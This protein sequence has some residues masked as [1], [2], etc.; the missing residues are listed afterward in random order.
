[1]PV[2]ARPEAAPSGTDEADG[3]SRPDRPEDPA[4]RD[5]PAFRNALAATD[6]GQ[7][8]PAANENGAAAAA[9]RVGVD[10]LE[11]LMT[12]AGE[13]VLTRNQLTQLTR[14]A[15]A[16]PMTAPVQRLSRLATELQDVVMKTRMQ[17][18]G[19]AWNKLPRLVRDLSHELGKPIELV[20]LGA[21]T[22]LDRQVLEQ[23]R[24]PLTHIV[25]N[26]ADHG[27]ETASVRRAAG[28]P[29]CG[30]IVLKASHESGHVVIEVRD[31]GRGLDLERI[32]ARIVARGLATEAEL[33]AM[34]ER[35]I[36]QYIFV[37]GFSTAEAVTSVSGRG[38][39]MDVVRSNI[40]RISG[41]VELASVPG[42]GTTISIRI[43]LTLAIVPGLVVQAAGQRF[44]LPQ[45][46]V[47]ELVRAGTGPEDAVRVEPLGGGAVLRLRDA[48]LPLVDLA[49]LLGLA[50]AEGR[51]A[52][53]QVIIVTRAAGAEF[54][55]TV[56]TVFDTE[57]IVV[58]PVAPPL[59]HL[60]PFGGTTILGDGT[61]TMILDPIGVARAAAI[62][63]HTATAS[64][65]PAG[66]GA[67]SSEASLE[68]LLLFQA[69]GA[70][71][72]VPLAAVTRLETVAGDHVE[73]SGGRRLVQYRG[74]LM[75]L[76]P[77]A[78]MPDRPLHDVLVLQ[79]DATLVGV[80]VDAI[81]DIVEAAVTLE[82]AGG[83]P[84]VVGT[85][86]IAG[87][88]TELIDPGHY[89]RLADDTRRGATGRGGR[90]AKNG[91][92]NPSPERR[93]A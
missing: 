61:V 67:A 44:V 53:D 15:D 91:R 36:Q 92:K 85:A 23:I 93:V 20:M 30:H 46:A 5:A 60:L 79:Q 71:M 80:V 48:L 32:R 87:R 64:E 84:G 69:G 17:P 11:Q 52:R 66:N 38:V 63:T 13:L 29:E 73:T 54:G 47:A 34:T 6:P 70:P 33:A 56:D 86:V 76:I 65:T 22:E 62:A 89:I 31:D 51:D 18:I 2:P 88:A 75:P 81:V 74:S 83:R 3:P 50:P 55:L 49:A 9:V 27:L 8:A 24:D 28:K 19:S 16:S 77:V 35:Q 41:T 42:E 39:G 1:M 90:V 12:L 7:P 68:T 43:P 45:L 4:R 82:M 40:E 59:R 58:K 10:T 37:P 25:R 57:E 78:G 26:S 14:G 72:A 21:E